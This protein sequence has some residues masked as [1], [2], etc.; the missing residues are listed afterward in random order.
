MHI[1]VS[2]DHRSILPLACV[3]AP[4]NYNEK[5]H[6]PT[7]VERTREVLRRARARLRSLIADSQYSSGRMR[8]LGE[9][10]GGSV[11]VSGGGL[12]GFP[13]LRAY[14]GVSPSWGESSWS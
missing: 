14:G 2:A 13:G 1:Q 8:R 10:E 7:L 11:V 3:L 9:V 5:R 12:A 6:G 4:A